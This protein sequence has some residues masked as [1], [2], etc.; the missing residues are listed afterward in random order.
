MRC[1]CNTCSV[2]VILFFS[3]PFSDGKKMCLK[4]LVMSQLCLWK[5]LVF[6]AG[7]DAACLHTENW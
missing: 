4:R 2:I 7:F 3:Y 6:I 5:L 1:I